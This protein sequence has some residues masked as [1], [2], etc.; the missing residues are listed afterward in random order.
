MRKKTKEDK[1]KKFITLTRLFYSIFNNFLYLTCK[2]YLI[3]EY[4]FQI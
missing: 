4:E 3:Y 2:F 1:V